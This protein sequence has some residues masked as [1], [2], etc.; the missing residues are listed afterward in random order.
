MMNTMTRAQCIYKDCFGRKSRIT[1]DGAFPEIAELFKTQEGK[2]A[3]A[4]KVA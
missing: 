1:V 2:N 3:S 4:R